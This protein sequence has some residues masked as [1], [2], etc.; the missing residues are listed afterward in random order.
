MIFYLA[1]GEMFIEGS[2]HGQMKDWNLPL[3]R[4]ITIISGKSFEC[5]GIPRLNV[6]LPFSRPETLGEW[7]ISLSSRMC[8]SICSCIQNMKSALGIISKYCHK[9]TRMHLT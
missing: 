6:F 2:V 3:L 9:S 7:Q 5:T 4:S 1:T 8:V